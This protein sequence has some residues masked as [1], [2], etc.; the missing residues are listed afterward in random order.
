MAPPR[1]DE[2]KDVLSVNQE[3][4]RAFEALSAE[5]MR[6]VWLDESY[7]TCIHPGWGRILGIAAVMQSWEDIFSGAFG[8]RITVS[9]EITRIQGDFAW[10]T[11]TEEIETRLPDGISRGVVEA[12]NV[13]ERRDGAWKMVHHHGSP[14]V[15]NQTPDGEVQLH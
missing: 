4:Y 11:C 14:L 1:K 15:R 12:T 3:F 5:R 9:D 6:A 7:V 2:R 13:F 8:M 10:V